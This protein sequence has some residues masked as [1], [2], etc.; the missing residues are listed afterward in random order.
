GLAIEDNIG[1]RS[2]EYKICEFD[3]NGT[4]LQCYNNTSQIPDESLG[5]QTSDGTITTNRFESDIAGQIAW[6]MLEYDDTTG[7]I[8]I[9]NTISRSTTNQDQDQT[10]KITSEL[11]VLANSINAAIDTIESDTVVQYCMTGRQVQGLNKT[12]PDEELAF[13]RLSRLKSSNTNTTRTY[14]GSTENPRFP[15][16]TTQM[17]MIIATQAIQ[18]A[19]EN[20]YKKYDTITKDISD[21]MIKLAERIAKNTDENAL[22]ARRKIA[23]QSCVNYAQ[24]SSI[25]VGG[26]SDDADSDGNYVGSATVNTK[27]YKETITST[28][29]PST[30]IC[31]RCIRKQGC[32]KMKGKN[33]R[34]WG[35]ENETCNDIQF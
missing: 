6:D 9:D 4:K 25:G 12:T 18:I 23:R 16:L 7:R 1:A 17:R 3:N 33:C 28:F 22:D 26:T 14:I 21:D 5:R 20:Y 8:K 35:N 27:S 32:A 30:L 2:L 19:K 15:T 11:A 34:T 29:N 31:H 13:N 10:D 24:S